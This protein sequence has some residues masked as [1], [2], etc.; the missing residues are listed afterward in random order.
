M[1]ARSVGIE[2]NTFTSGDEFIQL[3]Q[4]MPWLRFD[5]VVID[6][7]MP[8]LGGFEVQ[9]QL[10]AS[11][12]KFPVVFIT[13]YDDDELREKAL[14]TG[15]ATVLYKPVADAVFLQTVNN[16]IKGAVAFD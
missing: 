5:C 12:K 6:I 10:S 16:A 14:A 13:A 7:Q 9:S 1:N 4:G 8:R 11:G 3:V 15:A 2:V